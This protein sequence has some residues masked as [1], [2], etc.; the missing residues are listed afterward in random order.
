MLLFYLFLCGERLRPFKSWKYFFELL[1]LFFFFNTLLLQS[2]PGSSTPLL[3]CGV[4]GTTLFLEILGS[5]KDLSIPKISFSPL[6]LAS[7]VAQHYKGSW[8][9]PISAAGLRCQE[10]VKTAD[11][12]T[13]SPLIRTIRNYSLFL[14]NNN[15]IFFLIWLMPTF[16]CVLYTYTCTHT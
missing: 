5:P 4:I 12:F 2:F 13:P 3:V 7:H 15:M 14:I 1:C 11:P 8:K 9:N 6:F 10:A 16:V